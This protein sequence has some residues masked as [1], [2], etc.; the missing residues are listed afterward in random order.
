MKY[1]IDYK[2]PIN[3]SLELL[4][5]KL[6]TFVRTSLESVILENNIKLIN[7]IR[8]KSNSYMR[9]IADSKNFETNIFI[10]E[11]MLEDI[12]L[13]LCDNSIYAHINTIK[14]G[15]ISV[16]N[17]I[18]AGICGKAILE[19]DEIT[20]VHNIT[21]INIRIPNDIVNAGNYIFNLLTKV[22]FKKSFLLYS[23]PGVGK[24]TILRDLI[25]KLE[26]KDTKFRYAVIDTKE[27]ITAGIKKIISGDVFLSYP[28]GL[29]IELATKS[30]TPQYIICDEISSKEEAEAI[31]RATNAGVNLI[32]TTHAGSIEDLYAK[33]IIKPLLNNNIFDYGVGIFRDYGEKHYNFTL[34]ELKS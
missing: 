20:G 19:N 13:M 21:S 31:L 23:S 34:T 11:N 25:T 18:R 30:M 15:Y 22:G 1:L 7:E 9:L 26:E 14:D 28:K 12:L 8:L 6:P 27:E 17:G 32:A 3:T 4:Y 24:T 29:A 33:E 5:N 2:A 10:T 16:G